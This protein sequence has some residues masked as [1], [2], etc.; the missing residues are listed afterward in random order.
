M[1]IGK[2]NTLRA[3]KDTPQGYYLEDNEGEEILLPVKYIPA[4][5]NIGDEIEVY[6]YFD[7]EDR[8]IATTLTPNIVLDE[9]SVL[10]VKEVNEYG[11]FM[12]WGIAKDL[13]VP[14]AE[15]KTPMVKGR[16]YIVIMYY[17]EESKRLA[18]S[19]KYSDFTNDENPD[20]RIWEE[21]DLIIA[22]ESDLGYNVVINGEVEGLMYYDDVF[23]KIRYG[24]KMLGYIKKIREDGKIDV[25]LQKQGYANVRG[26]LKVIVDELKINNGHLTFNDKSDPE[27]IRKYFS[28][29]KKT[30]KKAI[31]SLYKDR[32]IRIEDD[33]IHLV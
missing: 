26:N 27:A 12:D 20:F 24:D 28:M 11:A 19:S 30:F 23:K 21:V 31:G 4:G 1:E 15:Q 25:S 3:T 2:Y 5:V 7:S 32:I 6:C 22:N 14:F 13:F 18:A 29:S 9:I 8:P 16:P 17:D 10:K 33:G